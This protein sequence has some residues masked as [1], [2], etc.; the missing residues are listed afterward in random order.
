M[1]ER[2]LYDDDHERFRGSVRTFLDQRVGPVYEDWIDAGRPDRDLWYWAAELGLLGIMVPTEYGGAGVESFKFNAVFT[3]EASSH[4]Y[5]LGGLRVQV[6]MALPYLLA[7]CTEDQ[8]RE[9][10]PKF[11][12]GDLAVALA[13]TEPDAGSDLGGIS[14][15]ARRDGDHYV[16]NGAK[17]MI[18]SGLLADLFLLV[19]RTDPHSRRDG[20]SILLVDATTEGVERGRNLRKIGLQAQDLAELFFND[21]VVPV[22]RILGEENA[23]FTYLTSNLPQERLSISIASQA[24]ASAAV[25]MTVDHVKNREAFGRPISAFQNTRFE[26]AS[27]STEVAAGQAI[28]DQAIEALDAGTLTPADAARVKLFI[29]EMQGRVVDRCL[30]L[31]GGYG[32]LTEYPIAR[33]YSDARVTRLYGG[34]SEVMRLIIARDLGL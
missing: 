30:Q 23:G 2:N 24:A 31:F 34:S 6:D 12:S 20:L 26:L 21:V 7:Y 8:K 28:V 10:L 29:T 11:V 1:I 27:C 5:A 15:S 18:S 22:D 19:V 32:Y 9:L 14:T 25:A 33:L 3:E 13:M 16:V 17:T 4:G